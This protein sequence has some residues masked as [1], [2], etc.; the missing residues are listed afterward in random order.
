MTNEYKL[1]IQSY[2]EDEEEAVE[3]AVRMLGLGASFDDVLFLRKE[4]QERP[5]E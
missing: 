3:R 5:E 4:P 2:G 1:T